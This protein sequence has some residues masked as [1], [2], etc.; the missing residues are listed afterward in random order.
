MKNFS[1]SAC[2]SIFMPLNVFLKKVTKALTG[3]F[4]KANRV[5]LVM[6][7]KFAI[8]QIGGYNAGYL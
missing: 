5:V 3:R 4:I 2:R 7:D 8:A 1:R 6:H